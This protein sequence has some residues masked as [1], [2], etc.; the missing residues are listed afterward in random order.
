MKTHDQ[1]LPTFLLIWVEILLSCP[2][3]LLLASGK[4]MVTW[5]P[6]HMCCVGYLIGQR[7]KKGEGSSEEETTQAPGP[8]S[9]Y[10]ERAYLG[11]SCRDCIANE[12]L[13]GNGFGS[14]GSSRGRANECLGWA[15]A[16]QGEGER[17]GI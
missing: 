15:Q 9:G 13:A 8:A 1:L 5:N 3:V 11:G 12:Y 4:G 2:E 16:G 10:V 7:E 17:A 6:G 14:R